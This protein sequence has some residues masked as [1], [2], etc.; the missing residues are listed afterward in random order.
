MLVKVNSAAIN[1]LTAMPV[2]IEVNTAK[3]DGIYMVGLPDNAVR[4]SQI[5]VKA[6]LTNSGFCLPQK[7]TT[8]NFAPADVRKEG[9]SYDLPVAIGLMAASKMVDSALLPSTM[10]VGELG[11]DGSIRPVKGALPI[12]IKARELGYEKLIDRKSV[13]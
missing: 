6:A 4:E 13:V 9:S 7:R 2:V 10:L 3:G 5:R 11:L 8:I 12:A 1:G